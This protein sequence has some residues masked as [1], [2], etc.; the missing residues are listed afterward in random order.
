MSENKIC[1]IK[2]TFYVILL[3]FLLV[4]NKWITF[5]VMDIFHTE[6]SNI[7][8]ISTY[9][10]FYF[11]NCKKESLLYFLCN[12]DNLDH[13]DSIRRYI[14]IVYDLLG[15]KDL[16]LYRVKNVFVDIGL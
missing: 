2:F 12:S 4:I 16:Y 8:I 1:L 11:M 3:I 14:L 6:K 15:V 5:N 13:L 9:S 7:L 10:F